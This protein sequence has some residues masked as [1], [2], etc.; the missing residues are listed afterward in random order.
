MRI[1]VYIYHVYLLHLCWRVF[2]MNK[3]CRARAS[4][5]SSAST[6]TLYINMYIFH[7]TNVLCLC[8]CVDGIEKRIVHSTRIGAAVYVTFFFLLSHFHFTALFMFFRLPFNHFNLLSLSDS[9]N[10]SLFLSAVSPL[11]K[12]VLCHDDNA[13]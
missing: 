9:L 6:P 12:R 4:M 13:L 3:Y 1:Y 7:N 2:K 10:L 8:L 5:L 11:W